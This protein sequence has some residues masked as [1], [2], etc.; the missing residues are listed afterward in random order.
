MSIS[1]EFKEFALK[2]NMIDMAVGIVIGA[3]FST[4]VNSLVSN[5]ITPPLGLLTQHVDFESMG[6]VLRE[7]NPATNTEAV[8]IGY[9]A[10]LNAIISFLIMAVA[11]FLVIKMMN[12]IREQFE[13]SEQ[14]PSPTT[15]TC[16]YCKM[17][18]P[19]GAAR[20]GHCT[21]ELAT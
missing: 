11:I 13:R 15:K 3:A 14:T 8:A 16:E 5:I 19:I 6:L 9:G 4:V 18:V 17:D 7:A 10:F 1:K 12:R 2:G 21:S 20:C